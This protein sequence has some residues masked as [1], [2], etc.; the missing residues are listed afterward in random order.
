MRMCR[1]S[2]EKRCIAWWCL[3]IYMGWSIEKEGNRKAAYY[4]HIKT[5][6]WGRGYMHVKL[7]YRKTI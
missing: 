2:E 4:G 3:G 1:I 7:L 6:I 5:G